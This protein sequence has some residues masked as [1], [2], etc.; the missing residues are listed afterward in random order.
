MLGNEGT[1]R[2]VAHPRLGQRGH[3]GEV[4]VL[5]ALLVGETGLGEAALQL[6]LR[7][8]DHLMIKERLQVAQV[9]GVLPLGVAR[10]GLVVARAGRQLQLLEG[11]ADDGSPCVSTR[12][13]GGAQACPSCRASNKRL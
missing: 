1:L 7:A 6:A 10:A 2:E 8:L 13:D 5:Q 4:D 11:S 12:M 9:A 3:G